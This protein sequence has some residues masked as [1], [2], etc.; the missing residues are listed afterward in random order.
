MLPDSAVLD[1]SFNIYKQAVPF[2]PSIFVVVS[3]GMVRMA[4]LGGG[5]RLH[6]FHLWTAE[7]K[8][9][10]LFSVIFFFCLSGCLDFRDIEAMRRHL[11]CGTFTG[12]EHFFWGGLLNTW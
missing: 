8:I 6:V 4:Y 5:L 2:F 12:P 9:K 11:A 1:V 10:F 7:I 3:T